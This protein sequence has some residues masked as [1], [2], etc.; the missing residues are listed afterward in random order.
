M[1]A[2]KGLGPPRQVVK[3]WR[4]ADSSYIK[5]ERVSPDGSWANIIMMYA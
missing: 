5:D 3:L 2:I 1:V 4:I